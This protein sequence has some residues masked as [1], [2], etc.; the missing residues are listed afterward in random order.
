MYLFKPLFAWFLA[1]VLKICSDLFKTRK[2]N[3]KRIIGSGG[4]PSSHAALTVALTTSLGKDFG[5]NDP[6]VVTAFIFTLV[7]LYDAAGVRR[8]VGRQAV[9]L[10]K[11]IEEL[12]QTKQITEKRLKELLGH[13]P[14]QVLIGI[15]LGFLVGFYL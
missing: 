8:A 5:L 15:L 13:T 14:L 11:I 6:L 2:V 4:M 3:L 9:V 1:Q 10:N 12:M 7:V